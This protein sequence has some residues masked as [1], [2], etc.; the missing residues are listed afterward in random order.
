MD[1]DGI[2]LKFAMDIYINI[3]L[4][5]ENVDTIAEQEAAMD[6]AMDLAEEFMI[7]YQKRYEEKEKCNGD[8]WSEMR[9]AQGS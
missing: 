7:R 3:L 2:R 8:E 9:Q 4:T 6:D 5:A 1:L